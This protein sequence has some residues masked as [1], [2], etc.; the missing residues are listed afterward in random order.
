MAA[1]VGPALVAVSSIDARAAPRQFVVGLARALDLG[2]FQLERQPV[3]RSDG[4][5]MVV[6]V[7]GAPFYIPPFYMTSGVVWH[8]GRSG[9]RFATKD[10]SHLLDAQL[11]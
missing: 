1:G 11:G 6:S 8:S 4:R 5:T 7:G 9:V 3:R 2:R 10:L